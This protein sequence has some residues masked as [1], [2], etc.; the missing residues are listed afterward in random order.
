MIPSL[1]FKTCL[2]GNL[3]PLFS[4]KMIHLS[5]HSGHEVGS[6]HVQASCPLTDPSQTTIATQRSLVPETI[7]PLSLCMQPK[8][9]PQTTPLLGAS[10]TAL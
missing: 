10:R 8:M 6:L 2:L 4:A 1:Y 5:C 7:L 9:P 3:A